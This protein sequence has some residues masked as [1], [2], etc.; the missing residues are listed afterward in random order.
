[1]SNDRVAG[2][3]RF[4]TAAAACT[5]AYEDGTGTV[6]IATARNFPDALAA[7]GLAGANDACI[8]LVEVD[9]VPDATFAAIDDLNATDA[10][11]VGGS[12]A[13]G[14]EVEAALSEVVTVDRVAGDDRFETAAAI[15]EA[16]GADG[17]DTVEDGPTAIL[18]SGRSSADALAAGPLAAAGNGGGQFPIL[19]TEQNDLPQATIDA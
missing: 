15:A 9:E 11:I 2:A 19:L 14:P 17:I 8:L 1:M 3:D 18:A 7:S 4:G 12:A 10:I 13:V 16:I 5:E 6:I